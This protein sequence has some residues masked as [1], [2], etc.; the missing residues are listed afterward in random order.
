MFH[1]MDPFLVGFNVTAVC[2]GELV[3]AV[4]ECFQEAYE[5]LIEGDI[6]L[7]FSYRI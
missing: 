3:R 2:S 7:A 1:V 5:A 4:K 6:N